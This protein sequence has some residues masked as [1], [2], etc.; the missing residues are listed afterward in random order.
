MVRAA[1]EEMVLWPLYAA[2]RV[3]G[4]SRPAYEPAMVVALLL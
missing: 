1:V 4:K 2:Y 3:D